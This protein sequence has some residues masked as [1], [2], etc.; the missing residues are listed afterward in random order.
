MRKLLQVCF[1]FIST[2]FFLAEVWAINE[3]KVIGYVLDNKTDE[4]L[5][6]A[7]VK[8][9]DTQLGSIT[10]TEGFFEI[11]DVP[12]KTYNITA[13]YVGYKSLTKFNLV[14]RSGANPEVTFKLEESVSELEDV[15]VVAN[16][17][18]KLEETPLSIQRLSREEVATY[19][20]GNNDIAR[21][22][23]SLPGVSGSVGGFRND[24][25]IRGGAPNEN[26]YYLDGI[27]IPNINHFATQ[28]SAG[29]P[30]GLLN[31]SFFEGV[32]LT[33][34]SFGAQYDNVL[35][36]VL[37][38]DQRKGNARE[39]KTNL[40][41]GASETALTVEGPLFKKK[42]EEESKTS[43]IAS[44]RRSYLQ[45]LFQ[46]L[47]LPI[48]PDYW[49]YQY[50]LTHKI[51]KYNEIYWTG[52]GS[53]DNF[54]INVPEEYDEEQQATLEQVPVIKQWT[55]TS[56]I[57]WKRKFKD[58]SGFLTT[59]LSTNILNNDFKRYRDNINLLD[60]YFNNESQEWETKLRTNMSKFA[61][62]WVI[63]SGFDI[64]NADYSNTTNELINNFNYNT[65]LNFFRYGFYGQA[66]TKI[67]QEK[68]GL[69]AGFRMD[70]NTFTETGNQIYRTF[71]PRLSVS[72]ALDPLNKWTLNASAGRYYKL[73]PYTI[74]GFANNN[75]EKVNRNVDYIRSD[76]LVAGLEYLLSPSARITVEGFYK[77]YSN[78]PV[79][80]ISGVSLANLGGGFEVLGNEPVAS[81][82]N[83]RTYGIEFLLQQ[84]Y[85][86][87]FYGILAYTYYY[88]RFSGLDPEVFLPSV[89]DNRH[90]LTFTGGYKFPR[91][92]EVGL[93]SRFLGQ[94]PYAPL[95]LDAT[96]T[97]YP[98]Q[99]RDF[100][101]LGEVRLDPFNQIDIRVD[102]KWNFTNFTL[103][104]FL[105]FQ[106][107]L[108]SNIPS[109]P[110][111]GLARD[112]TGDLI[113]PR[114][115]T[116]IEDVDNSSLLPIIGIVID[117]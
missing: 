44:A 98:A 63:N 20:G 79:S 35:S 61:G 46:L 81:I 74:L 33:A 7:T 17:F 105:E 43:F 29:G 24:V 111:Y 62:N 60:P 51:N 50:K 76:H 70:G 90:L 56:G 34:S 26:V 102:K 95:D 109:E 12:A 94:T 37:Q 45:F 27:E 38:F 110:Q 73:P 92:W 36:G 71:S 53:I 13:S 59:A 6:G 96:L 83:G 40:R 104:L 80:L 18:Q 117:F 67:W 15:V 72:Y 11:S 19:P 8:I 49:D 89:W 66:S 113:Q 75:G 86:K 1:I 77:W 93:R 65:D 101:R 99:V 31:V 82:G 108:V 112:E 91:N 68:F 4:P 78:Y 48:L 103:D 3:G 30:V 21:V 41:V 57:S 85:T 54:S 115:L 116:Q 55:T 58:N 84:K 14:V 16:P 10:N 23:Q 32:T 106:N 114:Q 87:N 52:V 22:V 64:Q 9:N 107:V 42:G 28:G 25:I 88:S 39:F 69:S 2:F 5:I 100:N 47:D 97:N